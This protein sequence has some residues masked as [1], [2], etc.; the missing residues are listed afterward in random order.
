M[1]IRV[2]KLSLLIHQ[3]LIDGTY[4]LTHK[5]RIADISCKALCKEKRYE[6][7]KSIC[8]NSKANQKLIQAHSRRRT[9]KRWEYIL[10]EC[11]SDD[12]TEE[13]MLW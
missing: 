8:E 3:A 11:D 9:H 1:L 4:L 7:I 10:E 6:M 12:N 5:E 2:N 13:L